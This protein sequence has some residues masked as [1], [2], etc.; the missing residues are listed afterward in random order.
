M[1]LGLS[2][3]ILSLFIFLSFFGKCQGLYIRS[4]AKLRPDVRVRIRGD[5]VRVRIRQAR[6]RAVVRRGGT[7]ETSEYIQPIFFRGRGARAH[8]SQAETRSSCSHSRGRSS[9]SH[10]PS[11]KSRRSS[12]RRNAGDRKVPGW[13][14]C[15]SNLKSM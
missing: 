10:T 6:I 11:P 7:Q 15:K 5:V 4:L 13:S 3:S 1:S 9:S 8:K 12:P 2:L 14:H